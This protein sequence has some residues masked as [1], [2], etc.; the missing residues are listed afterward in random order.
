MDI[1]KKL[2]DNFNKM[3]AFINIE[4]SNTFKIS[5]ENLNVITN[6]LI[7]KI[8]NILLNNNYNFDENKIKVIM[9]DSVINQLNPELSILINNSKE[10][11]TSKNNNIYTKILSN[12][13]ENDITNKDNIKNFIT[14][15]LKE[16]NKPYNYTIINNIWNNYMDEILKDL[17]LNDSVKNLIINEINIS[18]TETINLFNKLNVNYIKVVSKELQVSYYDVIDNKEV[19]IPN[20]EI[21]ELKD[22][23]ILE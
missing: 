2:E 7:N 17:D 23:E 8:S 11:L 22:F 1:N 21:V 13:N 19:I 16:I 3:L 18:N 12:V 15:E 20:L 4:V 6:N 14:E 5:N 9:F 10:I